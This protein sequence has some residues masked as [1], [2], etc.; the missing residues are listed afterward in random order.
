MNSTTLREL[1][2]EARLSRKD[3]KLLIDGLKSNH[4][5]KLKSLKLAYTAFN[6]E[7]LLSLC[8]FLTK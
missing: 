8:D 3:A 7:S 4:D 5:I 6:E 1:A 2:I